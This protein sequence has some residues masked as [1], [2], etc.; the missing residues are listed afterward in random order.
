MEPGHQL[1]ALHAR[2]TE[3]GRRAGDVGFVI[4][5]SVVPNFTTCGSTG[6]RCKANPPSLHGP[7]WQWTR[8]VGGKTVSKRLK[9]AEAKLYQRWIANGRKL[10]RLVAQM[11]RISLKASEL[12]VKT[13]RSRQLS[14]S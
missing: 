6:C 5:G 3:L 2:L 4:R 10:D 12:L 11:E 9:P 7:Y 14:A 1:E 13:G 8:S